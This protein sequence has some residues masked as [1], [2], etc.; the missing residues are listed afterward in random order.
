[1]SPVDIALRHR[2]TVFF[3]MF[4]AVVLG[5]IAYSTLPRETFP[6]I[7]V[8]LIIAVVPYPGAAP[9]EVESQITTPLE[10]EL[11]GLNGL[12]RL[13]SVSEEGMTVVT[14]EFVSGTDINTALQKV[15][16]RVDQAEVDFPDA[17]E[18]PILQEINFSDFPIIQVNLAGDVGPVVLKRLA[19][20]L[21]DEIEAIPGVL[22]ATVVGGREREVRVDVDPERLWLHG[23]SLDDVVDAVRDE[24][25]SIPGG[26][27]DL[28]EV[29]YAVRV[30]GEVVDPVRVADF[31][32]EARDGRPVFVRDVAEVSFGFKDRTSFARINAQE[33]VALS[34]QKRVGA[35]II[36][37]ADEIKEI[38]RREELDWPVGVEATLL[39]DESK[40]I[41]Q[42]V[43]DLENSILSGLLLVVVVLMFALGLRNSFFV[44]L[45]IPF[46]M[47]LTFVIIQLS[48]VT[49]NMVVLFAMVLSVGMLVDN[50]VVVIENIYRHMQEGADAMTAASEAT[51][52]V[53][54]AIAVSTF[55]TIGA[56]APLFVWP[57]VIGDFMSYLP[58]TV[59]IALLAS[60]VVAFSANPVIC[61]AFMRLGP[62]AGGGRMRRTTDAIGA[63][64]VTGYRRLLVRSLDHRLVVVGATLAVFAIVVS[65]FVVFNTGMEFLPTMEPNQI[66]VDV[67]LAPGAR[68]EKTDRV[69]R[70]FE[71]RLRDLTD[72]RVMASGTGGG[73]RNEGY[74]GTGGDGGDPN[75]GRLSLDLVD[76][77]LRER[78][79]FI[80]LAEVRELTQGLPGV[81][82]DVDQPEHGP[83]VGDPLSIEIRGE[84]FVTLGAIAA[85]IRR[86]VAGIPGLV[87]LDDDFDLDRPEVVVS[88]DRTEAARLG[89]TTT[90]IASTI[91]T[92]ITG[93]DASTYRH[94]DEDIDITVRLAE[95][96]RRSIADLRRLVVVNEAGDQIPLDAVA[97]VER[98]ASLTSIRHQ[99]RQRMVTVSGKVITPKMA[100]PVRREAARLLAAVPDLLPSGYSIGFAGQSEEEEE[101]KEF[102]SGAFLYA[103]VIVLA[104]MVGK[105]D[106][107]AI[108]LIIL[109][110]VAMSMIGVLLGLLATGM[111]FGIIMTG[112]GVISLAGIVV[113]NAIV[114]LDYGEKLRARGLERREVVIRTGLRRLRPVLLTAITTILGLLPL[115][116]G[117]EFDFRSFV[118][119]TGSESSQY[120]RSMGIAVIFGLAFATFLTLVLVPVLYDALLGFRER[121]KRRETPT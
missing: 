106:S 46:S 30:P 95:Q 8:P 41:R 79:G 68:L 43:K 34:V 87:S 29:S 48:G 49:L 32:I 78:N 100:E 36:A 57:G 22:R 104:L 84:D 4:A 108:P 13:T 45:A 109:T 28:G 121:H 64:I 71:R 73:S 113:N 60:L 103:I 70:E 1:M 39:G 105:F 96:A 61:S 115:T 50:A 11:T 75:L 20:D 52:E 111:P 77:E 23:F 80:T 90:K 31:V 88:V 107:L 66:L 19:E 25:V 94:G 40:D 58:W 67:D 85:R 69:V 81:T 110:S 112:V 26:D 27:M 3:A 5:L 86:E 10:R 89:L 97:T 38:V 18:E 98:S 16:D 101:A 120:W 82:L 47:L 83:P 114:L 54:G 118:F 42:Q 14:V 116:I 59:S 92:A 74:G 93:T 44:G 12:K 53:G 76:R 35:N 119:S 63:T 62:V 24:N 7:E 15:R 9:S 72:L 55:T 6:D 21:Q 56:F 17:A 51:R 37:V 2:A 99:D 102:L 91:R 33:S 117:V 65:A